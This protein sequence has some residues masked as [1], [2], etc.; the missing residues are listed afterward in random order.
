[1]IEILVR[2]NF[3]PFLG[4]KNPL[5]DFLN[6]FEQSNTAFLL[7]DFRIRNVY[8]ILISFFCDNDF[9]LLEARFD[10]ESFEYDSEQ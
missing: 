4:L 9:S 8:W 3:K 7:N 2:I 6:F 5:L 10:G 1:M